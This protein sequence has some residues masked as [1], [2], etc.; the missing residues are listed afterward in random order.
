MGDR[1]V[2]ARADSTKNRQAAG[3][4]AIGNTGS[5]IQMRAELAQAVGGVIA[6]MDTTPI[7]TTA[8]EGD[9]LLAAADLVTLART[10]VER[11]YTGNVI[12]AHAPEMPTRFAKEL[13]QIVRGAVAIGMDRHNAL[14][15]AIRCARDSMPPLR[16]QIIDDVAAHRDSLVADVRRRLGKP[17]NTVDREVQALYMLGVLKCD[18]A[19]EFTER[20]GKWASKWYYS[21]ADGINPTAIDLKTF[22]EKSVHTPSPQE[23]RHQDS[24]SP[25]VLTDKPGNGSESPPPLPQPAEPPSPASATSATSATS[26]PDVADVADKSEGAQTFYDLFEPSSEHCQSCGKQLW[27]DGSCSSCRRSVS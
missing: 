6:G 5:E 18:E 25:C 19:S 4:Q 16:L 17:H 15:L 3:R 14:R 21:L 20:T 23:E 26:T 24:D 9:A 7:T 27:P 1:F 22:P 8:E 13:V 11:D 12:D 10:A 2:L